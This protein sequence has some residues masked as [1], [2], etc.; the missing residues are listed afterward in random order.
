MNRSKTKI[1]NRK[2]LS[3]LTLNVRFIKDKKH[4]FEVMLKE[5]NI[6]LACL[7]ET[8][9]NRETKL[10]LKNYKLESRDGY[11][12]LNR[13]Q[14]IAIRKDLEYSNLPTIKRDTSG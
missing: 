3:M 13:Q 14:I 9:T 12:F 2:S 7:Q 10:Y 4:E 5:N 6:D 1:T 11:R 8:V